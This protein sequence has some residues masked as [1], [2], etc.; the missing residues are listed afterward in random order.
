MT[1]GRQGRGIVV[2]ASGAQIT[3]FFGAPPIVATF[4]VS[5]YFINSLNS[6]GE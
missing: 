2:V 4:F 3:H 6:S 5:A 1:R